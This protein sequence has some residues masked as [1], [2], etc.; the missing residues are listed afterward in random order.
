MQIIADNSEKAII[1]KFCNIIL[2]LH[3][4]DATLKNNDWKFVPM[5]YQIIIL[6]HSQKA[7]RVQ[8][9]RFKP[10]KILADSEAILALDFDA[11]V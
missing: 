11:V 3:V 10:N 9:E 1:I 6:H 2:L 5:T 8:M 4:L 7:W